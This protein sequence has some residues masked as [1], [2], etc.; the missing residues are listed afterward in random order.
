MTRFILL[1]APWYGLRLLLSRVDL[2]PWRP[3]RRSLLAGDLSFS[4]TGD[5]QKQEG[6]TVSVVATLARAT[7]HAVTAAIAFVMVPIHKKETQ[8]V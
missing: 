1:S 2:S 4:L 8:P 5:L 3:D 7:P 6:F